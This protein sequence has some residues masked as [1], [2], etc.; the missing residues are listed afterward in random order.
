MRY[1]DPEKIYNEYKS[2][3]DIKKIIN[4]KE[5][6]RV[7]GSEVT[8]VC[9]KELFMIYID[10]SINC[11][12]GDVIEDENGNH[13]T[14]ESLAIMDFITPAPEWYYNMLYIQ[15]SIHETDSIGEYVIVC[16]QFFN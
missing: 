16:K 12:I 9:K 14:I 4:G 13:F 8:S 10:K 2:R 7:A 3:D 15:I 11:R 6:V 5:Y 1:I